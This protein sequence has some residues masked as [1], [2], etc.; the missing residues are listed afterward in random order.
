M[1]E[2]I[3]TTY[4]YLEMTLRIHGAIHPIPHS[5]CWHGVELNTEDF[6]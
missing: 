3:L 1:L 5:S 4:L 6:T 2:V